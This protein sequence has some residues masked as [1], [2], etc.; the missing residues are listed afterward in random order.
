MVKK[1]LLS[2]VVVLFLLAAPRPAMAGCTRDFEN[3]VLAAAK[4]DSF[5]SAWLA[6]CDCELDYVECLRVA[7]VGA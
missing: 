6:Y 5:W 3:C 1:T 7:V 4:L 2:V